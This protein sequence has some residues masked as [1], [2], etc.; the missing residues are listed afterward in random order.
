MV[1]LAEDLK[2]YVPFSL[3]IS[4]NSEDPVLDLEERLHLL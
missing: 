4:T 3:A 2:M 1:E